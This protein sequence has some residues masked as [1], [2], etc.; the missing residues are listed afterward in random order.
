M[1]FPFNPIKTVRHSC[2]ICHGENFFKQCTRILIHVG[3][4]N[5]IKDAR[6]DSAKTISL[7]L[8]LHIKLIV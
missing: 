4:D 6:D 5:Q 8:H 2:E 1:V 7:V 3:L